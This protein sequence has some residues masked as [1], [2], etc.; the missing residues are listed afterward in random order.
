MVEKNISKLLAYLT[1]RLSNHE[2]R[3]FEISFV[4]SACKPILIKYLHRLV[5]NELEYGIEGFFAIEYCFG[6]EFID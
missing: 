1:D 6:G 5:A 4:N 2:I 3:P